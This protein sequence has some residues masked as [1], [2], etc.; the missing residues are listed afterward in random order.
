MQQT[1]Q[2]PHSRLRFSTGWERLWSRPPLRFAPSWGITLG[3]AEISQHWVTLPLK[4]GDL[5]EGPGLLASWLSRM[6]R[7][8]PWAS[9]EVR[10]HARAFLLHLQGKEFSILYSHFNTGMSVLLSLLYW[11][12]KVPQSK[13]LEM[14]CEPTL[15]LP[16]INYR[17]RTHIWSGS[18]TK[19]TGGNEWVKE[20]IKLEHPMREWNKWME[21]EWMSGHLGFVLAPSLPGF[22][23]NYLDINS[24]I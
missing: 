12:R 16:I 15:S 13:A 21:A 8:V 5:Q 19:S 20:Q 1:W 9:E 2:P 4:S 3:G 11:V 6:T 22:S 17:I 10:H 7:P 18:N 23:F 14:F 24:M